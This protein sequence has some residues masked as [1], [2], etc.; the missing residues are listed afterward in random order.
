MANASGLAVAPSTVPNKPACQL[1]N[2][3][4]FYNANPPKH[5]WA[6]RQ[7]K[8][9][10]AH[11]YQLLIP[12]H[13][14][15]LEVGCADGD[16]LALL[17][18][19][20]ITGIDISAAQ[21]DRA[22]KRLPHVTFHTASGETISLGRK[23]DYIILSDVIGLAQD[24]QRLFNNLKACSHG[25]TRLLINYHSQLWRLPIA[26]ATRL[27][28]K[29]KQPLTSWFGRHDVRNLLWLTDWLQIH[30]DSRVALPFRLFGI[31]TLVNRYLAPFLG[32]FC[33][34]V[35]S[36][37][38]PLL[39]EGERSLS[40]SVIVPARNE[41]GNVQNIVDR[42][43]QMGSGTELVFVE[44]GS[45]DNTWDEIQ[46][47]ARAST[48]Q[49]IVTLRQR[50][51]G[52]GDAVREGFA[53][54]SGD[55]L[56]ILDADL[57]VPPEDLPK[58]YEAIASGKAEFANGVRLVYPMESGAMQFL[59]LCANKMFSVLFSWILSQPVKDTLCG[60]KALKRSDYIRIADNRAY[61]GD[62]DPFG[63]F[64]LLF[65]AGK[66]S[67]HIA[68]I[69]IRYCERTYGSTNIRRWSHGQ[70]LIRMVIFG[71]NKFRFV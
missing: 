19:R 32:P 21:I 59:N 12:E 71:A 54:A 6:S 69:P 47:V 7:Y 4:A 64:D 10:L 65:G 15:V 51:K 40:V 37:A 39:K 9:I 30:E 50:K 70:Q 5:S 8:Q 29:G 67:R 25:E 23:F 62:F 53:A 35:F 27:G 34:T 2:V 57:T 61:F 11:Y 44:G 68:D 60:T 13:A 48:R 58:F 49:K 16:L 33:L 36:A 63:D 43:P 31:G 14:S 56:M 26:V 66:L 20:D 52:K 46:R 18:N 41:A 22:R 55:V 45:T 1:D 28:L 24:V 17:P 38:R 3:A 42:V